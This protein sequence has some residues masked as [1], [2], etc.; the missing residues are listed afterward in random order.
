M[1]TPIP[2]GYEGLIPHL[3]C[4]RCAD[5]IEFYKKAFAAEE[6]TRM[7]APDG[8]RIMHAALRIGGRVL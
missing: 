6:L 2:K 8:K 4:D 1:P 5:A 3:K 7:P